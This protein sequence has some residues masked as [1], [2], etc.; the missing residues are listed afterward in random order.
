MQVDDHENHRKTLDFNHQLILRTFFFTTNFYSS[1]YGKSLSSVFVQ[2]IRAAMA[3]LDDFDAE[4]LEAE[5]AIRQLEDGFHDFKQ[6]VFSFLVIGD[7]G[8]IGD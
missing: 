8:D 5:E 4:L 6:W 7:M 3:S 2:T 1:S